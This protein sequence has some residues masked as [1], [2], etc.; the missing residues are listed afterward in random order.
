LQELIHIFAGV[1]ERRSHLLYLIPSLDIP[2]S[3]LVPA[4]CCIIFIALLLNFLLQ[5]YVNLLVCCMLV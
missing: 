5:L 2:H 4:S 3:I 1:S